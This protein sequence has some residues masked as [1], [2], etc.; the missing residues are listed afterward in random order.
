MPLDGE[1]WRVRE[2]GGFVATV[3]DGVLL[4]GNH[5]VDGEPRPLAAL[6]PETGRLRWAAAERQWR[7]AVGGG[8]AVLRAADGT[9]TGYGLRDGTV[10]WRSR[11]LPKPLA[12][13][14]W[15]LLPGL[16]GVVAWAL[17]DGVAAVDAETGAHRWTFRPP[18]GGEGWWLLHP[19]LRQ[20]GDLLRVDVT[21]VDVPLEVFD[22]PENRYEGP[23][24]H[25]TRRSWLL[26]PA[27]GADRGE[28]PYTEP[29][30]PAARVAGYL[31][32]DAERTYLALT[33]AW[34]DAWLVAVRSA[35]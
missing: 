18:P 5:L 1:V 30:P 12:A 21:Y 26:D 25:T 17:R 3:T 24:L 23:E 31:A 13:G 29:P 15:T 16:P 10:R 19:A 34:D 33:R 2:V 35:R 20:E 8:C 32:H 22:L 27:T 6:D 9:L 4:V 7:L 14:P 11:T 28:V